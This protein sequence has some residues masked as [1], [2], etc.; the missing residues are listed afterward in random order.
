MYNKSVVETTIERQEKVER[1]LRSLVMEIHST[2]QHTKHTYTYNVHRTNANFLKILKSRSKKDGKSK[3]GTVTADKYWPLRA[4]LQVVVESVFGETVNFLNI[5]AP[6]IVILEEGMKLKYPLPVLVKILILLLVEKRW[7]I[8]VEKMMGTFLCVNME[9][10]REVKRRITNVGYPPLKNPDGNRGVSPPWNVSSETKTGGLVPISIERRCIMFNIKETRF[11]FPNDIEP[12]PLV[13]EFENK[14]VFPGERV[15][16]LAASV[17]EIGQ[18]QPVVVVERNGRFYYLVGSRRIEACKK[19]GQTVRCEVVDVDFD[20]IEN[21]MKI[22]VEENTRRRHLDWTT[23][24]KALEK[25]KEVVKDYISRSTAWKVTKYSSLVP[26][27]R[28]LIDRGVLKISSDPALLGLFANLPEETQKKIAEVIVPEVKI[29]KI[30]EI[31]QQVREEIKR[32]ANEL[33]AK[34]AEIKKLA[35]SGK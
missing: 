22:Y 33:K 28:E 19:N 8:E 24:A 4:S 21:I 23:L 2:L 11:L 15:D 18:I 31:P 10:Y 26:E 34:E 6:P 13:Q 1:Y 16:N 9:M 17:K 27:I 29:E 3:V 32:M 5:L 30:K 12:H 7:G 14:E 20:D 25:A 35:D